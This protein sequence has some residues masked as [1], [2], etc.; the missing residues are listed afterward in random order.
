MVF[1]IFNGNY[2]YILHSIKH[3]SIDVYHVA[4]NWNQ[5]KLRQNGYGPS[6]LA[7]PSQ[8]PINLNSEAGTV[9]SK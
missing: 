4:V 6:S 3:A 7:D 9:N 2:G 8:E 1:Y 5:K